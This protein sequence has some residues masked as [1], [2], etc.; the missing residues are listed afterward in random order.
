MVVIVGAGYSGLICAKKLTDAGLKVRIFDLES[1]EVSFRRFP[2]SL[3]LESI[4][5]NS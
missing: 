3:S 2:R 5:K 4:M 1:Q